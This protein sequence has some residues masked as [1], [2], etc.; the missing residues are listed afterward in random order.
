MDRKKVKQRIIVFTGILVVPVFFIFL[1]SK[2]RPQYSQIPFFGEHIIT[3]TDTVYYQVPAYAFLNKKGDTI[4]QENFDGNY[5]IVTVLF[6]TCP[7]QCP[8]PFEQFKYLFYKDLAKNK[9]KFDDVKI[10]SHVVD[11]NPEDLNQL[12]RFL[13]VDSLRWTLVTGEHNAIYDVNLLR[14]TLGSKKILILTISV[15]PTN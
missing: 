8:M 11:A 15:A 12:Y 3:P 6:K 9:S 14:K 2:A 1:F 13:E 5:L 7:H 10:L 4:T